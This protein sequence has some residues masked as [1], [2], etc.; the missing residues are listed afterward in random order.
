MMNKKKEN[1]MKQSQKLLLTWLIEDTRLF[2][3][4]GTYITPSDFTEE[5]YGR[6]AKILYEQFEETKTVNPAK[7]ISMFESR[8]D[9]RE[10]ASLF[11]AHIH[12]IETRA[13][14]EKA[15][16]ETVVR[17]KKNSIDHRSANLAPTDMAG[18][19]QLVAD[20]RQLEQ[21]EKMH[22]SIE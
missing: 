19:Q 18:L 5:V 16:K 20:K 6:V 21:L 22:I 15:L 12:N 14:M 8:E 17:I 2:P 3:V 10:I 4:I 1:G 13:D 7:I 9:Q 11:N